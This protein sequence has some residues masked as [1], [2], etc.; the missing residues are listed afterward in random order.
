MLGAFGFRLLCFLGLSAIKWF[1]KPMKVALQFLFLFNPYIESIPIV[2][3]I[4][5]SSPDAMFR[6]LFAQVLSV[7]STI[8]SFI[9]RVSDNLKLVLE[10]ASTIAHRI[11]WWFLMSWNLLR[12][13][14]LSG[15]CSF[16]LNALL[17]W[18]NPLLTSVDMKF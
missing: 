14:I 3:E 9:I 4:L 17:I 12:Q 1:E 2:Q 11:H 5:Q 6:Q 18:G 16:H 15:T 8:I 13:T 10:L 7:L